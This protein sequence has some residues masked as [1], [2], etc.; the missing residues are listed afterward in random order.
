M[1][2][3]S[4]RLGG[5]NVIHFVSRNETANCS[6]QYSCRLTY[7]VERIGERNV[8]HYRRVWGLRRYTELMK[9]NERMSF[10]FIRRWR[11]LFVSIVS[12]ERLSGVL[13]DWTELRSSDTLAVF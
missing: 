12:G 1:S 10:H 4:R 5:K 13:D 6:R 9:R 11:R 8:V 2:R 3:S 7:V